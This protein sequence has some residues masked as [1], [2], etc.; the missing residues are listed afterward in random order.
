MTTNRDSGIVVENRSEKPVLTILVNADGSLTII[1]PDG[2]TISYSNEVFTKILL[3]FKSPD[4][5]ELSCGV[6]VKLAEDPSDQARERYEVISERLKGL[7][8]KYAGDVKYSDD[9]TRS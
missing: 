8:D 4:T 6:N 9:K 3:S 1:K 7:A 5:G 2:G